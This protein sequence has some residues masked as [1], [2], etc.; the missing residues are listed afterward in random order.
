MRGRRLRKNASARG[1]E[2]CWGPDVAGPHCRR[3]DETAARNLRESSVA[4]GAVEPAAFRKSF[5]ISAGRDAAEAARRPGVDRIHATTRLFLCGRGGSPS[6]YV[7]SRGVAGASACRLRADCVPAAVS[8]CGVG[9]AA[10]ALS[11]GSGCGVGGAASAL[12]AGPGCSDPLSGRVGYSDSVS[13]R[14]Q[15]RQS[16]S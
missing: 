5:R 2:W 12:A 10:L 16:G 7:V 15:W 13:A 1:R 8:G 14:K 3:A 4:R 9:G 6:L 11:A